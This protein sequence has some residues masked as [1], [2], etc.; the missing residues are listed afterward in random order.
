MK[1]KG[2]EFVEVTLHIGYGT[3]KSFKT[4]YID[5]H[6]MDSEEM[7]VS[8]AA[9]KKLRDAK[10]AKKPILAVGTSS[11]RT[12]ESIEKEVSGKIDTPNEVHRDTNLF[13]YPGTKLKVSDILLTNFAYPR[14]P[15][16][17]LAAAFSGLKPLKNIFTEALQ[18]D[19]LFYTYG[20]SILI[21]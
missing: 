14:T 15:I 5:E 17:A 21:L 9:I 11:V 19:Y 6:D 12:L 4:K 7:I 13:I 2:F 18:R 20:D 16:M 3:W 1:K 10:R 8:Q